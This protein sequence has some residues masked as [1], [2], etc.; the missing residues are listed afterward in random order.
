[1]PLAIIIA[2]SGPTDRDGNQ[3]FMKSNALKKLAIA[4]GEK[5]I[6]SFRY[7]KR[8]VKHMKQ[9]RFKTKV[10]FDDFISDAVAVLEYTSK[11][12]NNILAFM[13]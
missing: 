5:G 12:K 2:G 4:L 6:A 9:G 11:I 3:S 8:V 7:D 13:S 1:M 10:M